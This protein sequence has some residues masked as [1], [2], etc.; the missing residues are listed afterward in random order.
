MRPELYRSQC[1]TARSVP[2]EASASS[3]VSPK[4]RTLMPARLLKL[5][6]RSLVITAVVAAILGAAS[7]L[8]G[9]PTKQEEPAA[10][11]REQQ[12]PVV[13]GT[14]VPVS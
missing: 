2:V 3:S 14:D 13:E 12:A 10:S 9:R 5:D 1:R 6:A 11:T 7:V 4:G 8:V